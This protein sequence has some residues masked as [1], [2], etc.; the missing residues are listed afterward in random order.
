VSRRG[1]RCRQRERPLLAHWRALACWW[2]HL[3]SLALYSP[4]RV[5]CCCALLAIKSAKQ[6]TLFARTPAAL[7]HAP[8]R[9][10]SLRSRTLHRCTLLFRHYTRSRVSVRATG[11]SVVEGRGGG[12]HSRTQRAGVDIDQRLA[13]AT[14]SPAGISTPAR[15]CHLLFMLLW[16]R[17]QRQLASRASARHLVA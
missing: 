9:T 1:G 16:Y 2:R 3:A 13:A 10:H 12:R 5:C 7:H 8:C 11:E 14:A 4:R 17:G 6:I 15:S